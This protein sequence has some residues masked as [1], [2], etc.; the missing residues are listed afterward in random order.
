MT[1]QPFWAD[2][3]GGF[4]WDYAMIGGEWLPGLCVVKTNTKRDVQLKK[5]KDRSGQSL[6]DQGNLNATGTITMRIWT[7]PQWQEWLRIF[8]IIQPRREGGAKDPLEIIHPEPN[9]KGVKAIFIDEIPGYPPPEKGILTITMRF[10][11]WKP[12][13]KPVTTGSGG[14]RSDARLPVYAKHLSNVADNVGS[15]LG[16]FF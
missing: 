6:E 12:K 2:P 5:A 16:S 14:A 4:A 11:E 15:L 1:A 10:V 8:P 9:G 13:P 7:D 3:I